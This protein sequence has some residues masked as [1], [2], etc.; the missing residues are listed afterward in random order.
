MRYK[1]PEIEEMWGTGK[2]SPR[3]SEMLLLLDA[4]SRAALD[5]EITVTELWRDIRPGKLSF[6]PLWGAADVR[7][8]DWDAKFCKNVGLILGALKNHNK[9]FCFLFE[10]HP[11][12]LHIQYREGEP[13]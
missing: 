9:K 2:L 8:R 3:V 10:F 11:K 12:H 5:K 6:H 13:V 4:F 1:T 7:T